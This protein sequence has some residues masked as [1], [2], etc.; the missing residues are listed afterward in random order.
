MRF[1]KTSKHGNE[2]N[3]EVNDFRDTIFKF[4]ILWYNCFVILLPTIHK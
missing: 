4:L 3:G 1:C 2:S